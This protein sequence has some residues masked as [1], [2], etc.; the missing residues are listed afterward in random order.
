[1]SLGPTFEAEIEA[2]TARMKQRMAGDFGKWQ[3]TVYLP[4]T[5][6]QDSQTFA[7]EFLTYKAQAAVGDL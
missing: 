7:L 3:L 4:I 2:Q 6:H 5:L 1:M